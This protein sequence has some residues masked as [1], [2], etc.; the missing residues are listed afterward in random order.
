MSASDKIEWKVGRF[1]ELART[2]G[3]PRVFNIYVSSMLAY[4]KGHLIKW[5][6]Q[7]T[8]YYTSKFLIDAMIV[9]GR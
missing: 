1:F 3:C 4:G 9:G 5:K 7:L 8:Y 6:V 2:H